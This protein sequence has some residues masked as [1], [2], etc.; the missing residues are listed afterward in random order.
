M[1]LIIFFTFVFLF[2]ALLIG[3][4]IFITEKSIKRNTTYFG[5]NEMLIILRDNFYPLSKRELW[6]TFCVDTCDESLLKKVASGSA[7]DMDD[8]S[9]VAIRIGVEFIPTNIL[10]NKEYYVIS[11]NLPCIF[12]SNI[13]G[14]YLIPYTDSIREMLDLS[15]YEE[16]KELDEDSYKLLKMFSSGMFFNS[17]CEEYNHEVW[18][19]YTS[20]THE[21]KKGLF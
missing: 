8:I 19:N 2:F 12:F 15:N 6:R 17:D 20:L 21:F 14:L 3:R 16:V 7:E 10:A 11:E 5:I 9:A 4:S 18:V 13:Y 1:I